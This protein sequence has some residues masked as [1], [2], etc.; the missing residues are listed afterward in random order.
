MRG[1]DRTRTGPALVAA[2]LLLATSGGQKAW[3]QA[4]PSTAVRPDPANIPVLLPENMKW[5]D[6]GG[7]HFE[8]PLFGDPNKP[9]PYGILIRWL[10]YSMSRPHFHST[11]RYAYVLSGTWWVSDSAHYDP[12]TTY[13]VQPGTFATDIANK[14]HWDGAKDKETLVLVVGMGPMIT[15]PASEKK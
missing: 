5:E 9:G 4:L 11:D 13:P 3:A 1:S 12:A 8:T 10:P 15:Q 2:A 6:R 7:G 14:I